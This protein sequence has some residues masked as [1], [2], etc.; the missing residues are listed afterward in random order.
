MVAS[1][2]RRQLTLFVSTDEAKVIEEIRK[3]YN[4][5]QHRLIAAH[6]T[7]CRED[8]I[9]HWETIEQNLITLKQLPLTIYLEEV[10]R[11]AEGKGLFIPAK[12]Q[13]KAFDVLRKVILKG[14]IEQPRKHHAHL[15]L[16]HPRNST[17]TDAT[18][19][20]IKALRLPKYL[21][22]DT[23]TLIEQENGGVWQK[24]KTYTI[25][26]QH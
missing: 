12:E 18:F 10:K 1:N 23:I 25:G 3:K 20:E 15:T 24:L 2:K 19:N 14:A 11:F 7:L 26:S 16:M 4:P 9:E 17:C 13:Q 6:I 5:I 22:F 8:E 21:V